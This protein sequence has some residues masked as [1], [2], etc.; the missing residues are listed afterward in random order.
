MKP[1]K[2][3]KVRI[4]HRTEFLLPKSLIDKHGGV[5][6]YIAHYEKVRAADKISQGR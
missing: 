3:I 5:E 6:R 4:D 1:E 2:F